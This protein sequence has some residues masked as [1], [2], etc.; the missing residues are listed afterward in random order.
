MTSPS[1]HLI[2]LSAGGTGGHMIPAL[3]LAQDLISR[4]YEVQLATDKRGLRFQDL[5]QGIKLHVM[6]ASKLRKGLWGKITSVLTM[7]RGIWKARGLIKDLKPSVVVGFGG[8]P[9][10]PAVYAAQKLKVPTV[11]HESNAKMGSANL[12]LSK[13]ADRIALTWPGGKELEDSD[14]VRVVVTGNPVREEISALFTKPY[15]AL[16]MD[17]EIHILVMGGSLG[18]KIFS[19]VVPAALSLLPER[20]RRL[21]NITQ[22]CREED[23]QEAK[24]AYQDAGI[25]ARL[26]TFIEDVPR[27]LSKTHLFIG[28]SGS[29]VTE[30]AA[31]GRPAIYVPYPHHADRQQ[32]KN[33]E[34]IADK[35]GAWVM[36]EEAFTPEALHLRIETFLQNPQILFDAAEAARACGIPDAAR[37]LGN[38]VTALAQGWDKDANKPYDLT[39]GR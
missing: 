22:Q 33:A 10:V 4:G 29:T 35:G 18:A 12:F 38:L 37:R 39:Q 34:A 16:Q 7:G 11:I 25:N 19:E 31:A 20:Q 23:I 8:Y 26:E 14:R 24:K 27:E 2:L 9:S 3:A 6:P 15:P 13:K 17:E 28:R 32:F 30:L 5:F 36:A 21:L 1:S